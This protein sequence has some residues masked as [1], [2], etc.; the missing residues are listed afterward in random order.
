MG[1]PRTHRQGLT[2]DKL[3]RLLRPFGIVPGF[4]GPEAARLRGYRRDAFGD[5]FEHHLAAVSPA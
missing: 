3:A 5:A 1:G 2:K 4:V